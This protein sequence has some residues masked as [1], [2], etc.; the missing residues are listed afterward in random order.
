MTLLLAALLLGQAPVLAPIAMQELAER[1]RHPLA[2]VESGS[3]L[4]VGHADRLQIR[5]ADS[6]AV[7]REIDSKWTAFGFDEDQGRLLLVGNEAVWFNTRDWSEQGRVALEDATFAD[8]APKMI[9]SLDR[10][11]PS[12]KP[13]QALVLPGLDFYYCS[14]KGDISIG[15]VIEK[16][17]QAKPLHLVSLSSHPVE[18]ILSVTPS[19]FLVAF[20]NG[21]LGVAMRGRLHTLV[22]CPRVL[23]AA[24]AGNLA[25]SVGRE[26][27]AIYSVQSWKVITQR[28]GLEN[29]CAAFH[30]GTGWVLVGDAQGLRAWNKDKFALQHRYDEFKGGVGQLAIGSN[31]QTLYTVEKSTLRRWTL[32]E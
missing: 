2:M 32:K 21:S 5:D 6:L 22:G 1:D 4:A 3:F 19:G 26:D 18:R 15:S 29:R 17:L 30:A 24:D 28:S 7:L 31:S 20:E 10:T 27:E 23:F 9:V 11:F 8:G 13:G 16:K 12:L 25:V 14:G